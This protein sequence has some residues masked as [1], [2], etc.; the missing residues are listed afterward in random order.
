MDELICK[1]AP[2]SSTSFDL[3]PSLVKRSFKFYFSVNVL[4][5]RRSH[6][7]EDLWNSSLGAYLEQIPRMYNWS[8]RPFLSGNLSEEYGKNFFF[9]L[10]KLLP[11]CFCL[12][13]HYGV[14]LILV[15]RWNVAWHFDLLWG[16]SWFTYCFCVLLAQ[17]FSW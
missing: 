5:I 11:F 9:F 2:T 16:T 4:V 10:F 1:C 8:T 6:W 15:T 7:Q 17:F 14:G 3:S 12:N 13:L